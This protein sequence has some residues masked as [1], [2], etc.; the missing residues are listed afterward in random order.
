M[1]EPLNKILDKLVCI[2]C[3]SG[4]LSCPVPETLLCG[5]CQATF[6]VVNGI[7]CF[8]AEELV[9]FSEV[10]ETERQHFIDAKQVAYFSR[11]LISRLYN[12]YHQYAASRRTLL[13]AALTLDIGFGIGEHYPFVSA[14]EK[15]EASFIGLDIDRFKLEYFSA[16]HPELPVVQASALQIPFRDESFDVIQL[17]ATLEHFDAATAAAVLG[18]AMRVLKPGGHVLACYPAEGS[19]LLRTGQLIMHGWLRM[20]TGFDLEHEEVHHH[21]LSARDIQSLLLSVPGLERCESINYPMNVNNI[22]LSLFL[23]E[24]YRKDQ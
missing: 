6:R 23:N 13:P 4:R 8:V 16:L 9:S 10:N 14:R 18:E 7:P 15:A 21:V 2:S 1:P 3:A 11:S 17:L 22:Q 12:S 19:L 20:K 24:M 5:S